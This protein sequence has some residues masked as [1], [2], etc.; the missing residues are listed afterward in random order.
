MKISKYT[1]SIFEQPWWLDAVAQGNWR[2]I[3]IEENEE[4]I[5]RWPIVE[6]NK[7][8]CMPILTQTLGFWMCNS[9]VSTDRHLKNQRIIV[10]KLL[11]MVPERSEVSICLDTNNKDFMPFYWNYYKI[12]PK[13]SYRLKD[14]SDVD[15]VF[16]GFSGNVKNSIK[17]ARKKLELVH[18][19]DLDLL[20]YLLDKTFAKQ[21]MGNP[22]SKK[23][24]KDIY[25]A[26]RENNA[27]KMIFA[28]DNEGNI[29][30]GNLFIYDEN[31]FYNL[32]S[33]T[34]PKYKNSGAAALLLWE[35]I[36]IASNISKCFDFEGS[37]IKGINSFYSQF[38]GAQE[39]YFHVYKDRISNTKHK[40]N[41]LKNRL[42][43]VIKKWIGYNNKY[44]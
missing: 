35:G 27:C 36:N 26:A 7:M 17:R 41:L 25:S 18:S 1:N 5:A 4:V 34:D 11:K 19:E 42:K 20:L 21:N 29:H 43:T 8:I 32:I 31:V 14:I 39:V 12:T 9:I 15:I 44:K 2:E 30:S 28:K 33:G 38:G 23:L 10:D 37:M 24:I 3:L 16:K 6:Y 22:W 13:V 40:I